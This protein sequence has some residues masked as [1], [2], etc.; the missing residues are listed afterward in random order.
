MGLFVTACF[1][2]AYSGNPA[3]LRADPSIQDLAV[4]ADPTTATRFDQL[5]QDADSFKPVGGS[6]IHMGI[7]ESA[8][9]LRFFIV[10][11]SRAS[12]TQR[13]LEINNSNLEHVSLWFP[14][15][16]S[17]SGNEWNRVVVGKKLPPS[18]IELPNRVWD[19]PVP[20]NLDETR[21]VY[22][23]VQTFTIMWV[24]LAVIDTARL[25]HRI[26]TEHVLFGVFFGILFAMF[27]TGL[28]AWLLV[29]HRI[30]GF[31]LA[32]LFFLILYHFRVH[33]FLWFC[34]LP[35][36]VYSPLVWFTL[37]GMG[38]FMIVF[39]QQFLGLRK[40]LP[41]MNGL[42]WIGIALFIVQIVTGVLRM[43]HFTNR[44]AYVTGGIIP[45]LI[46][47]SIMIVYFRGFREAR[48][49]LLAW[50][51]LFMG[52]VIW[53][54]AAYRQAAIPAAYF[55]MIGTGLDALLL[56]L[57]VLDLLKTELREKEEIAAREKHY[58]SL[59]RQDS[60]TGLYN[61][62]YLNET[63]KRLE[64]ERSSLSGI[65]V[66]TIDLDDFK[67][68]NDTW[69]HPAGDLILAAMGRV[70][71]NHIR[72]TDLACRMGGDEFLVLLPDADTDTAHRV[73][74]A[75]LDDIRNGALSEGCQ[76][77]YKSGV[78]IGITGSREGDSFDGFLLRA[79]MALY[80]AKHEGKNR[81]ITI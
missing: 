66:I 64:Q 76:F 77:T 43:D 9:W 34:N 12:D 7:T 79:D 69:G 72:K 13:Y 4:Y 71:R 70:L 39:A 17:D 31:Y 8:V 62:R 41:V 32:Y 68:I 35:Y 30:F 22:I 44:L 27:I 18:A 52:T 59:A 28:F 45:I 56:A 2:L 60:L 23:R 40:R 73:A 54:T 46:L 61:R 49:Y 16:E 48:F 19:I 78:S 24:P 65:V 6:R 57:A 47:C 33:G 51:P 3:V 14:V 36:E 58:L 1:Y 75:L 67:K 63:V 29:R 81:I 5:V 50:F 55:F 74:S 25:V 26:W 80:K 11:A 21:P 37:G 53:A 15:K 10:P 20:A 42:L 38:I